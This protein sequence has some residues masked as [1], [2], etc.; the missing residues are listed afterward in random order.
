MC[1]GC[2]LK[3]GEV[4]G[5]GVGSLLRMFVCDSLEHALLWLGTMEQALNMW[6]KVASADAALD[7]ASTSEILGFGQ[8]WKI[9]FDVRPDVMW[10]S[11]GFGRSVDRCRAA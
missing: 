2:K 9:T 3:I 4:A 1:T 8:G 11:A 7:G 5:E 6:K 10:P